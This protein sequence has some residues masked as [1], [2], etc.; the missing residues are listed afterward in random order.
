MLR[1]V[2]CLACRDDNP[3]TGN[4]SRCRHL[5]PATI[6]L[7]SHLYPPAPDCKCRTNEE[8]LGETQE[9]SARRTVGRVHDLDNGRQPMEP[10]QSH[11][12]FD[13]S[14]NH[15]RKCIHDR[16]GLQRDPLLAAWTDRDAAILPS[17]R[18]S[19]LAPL[20]V[21]HRI[22]SGIVWSRL[23]SLPGVSFR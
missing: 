8:Q 5:S 2:Q 11:M 6:G 17:H 9:V 21:G 20:A 13:L 1:T 16:A 12:E 19:R 22:S 3:P 23:S 14:V 18:F 4:Q 15:R 10:V 7:T